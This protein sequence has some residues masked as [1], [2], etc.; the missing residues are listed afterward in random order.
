MRVFRRGTAPFYGVLRCHGTSYGLPAVM[1]PSAGVRDAVPQPPAIVLS[2][3]IADELFLL[4]L[5]RLRVKVTPESV[6][7][8]DVQYNQ[9]TR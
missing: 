1:T 6:G 8:G 7:S 4:G 9:I 3:T 2:D 5:A